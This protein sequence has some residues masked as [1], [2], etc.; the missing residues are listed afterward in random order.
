MV[1]NQRKKSQKLAE[2]I[3]DGRSDRIFPGEAEGEVPMKEARHRKEDHEVG[4]TAIMI[5]IVMTHEQM[6]MIVPTVKRNID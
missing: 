1:G 4:M 3:E 2:E 6:S 5:V